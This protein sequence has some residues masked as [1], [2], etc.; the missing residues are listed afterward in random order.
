[1]CDRAVHDGQVT[2]VRRAVDAGVLEILRCPVCRGRIRER[3]D[4]LLCEA[5][6][7]SFELDGDI[8]LF[9]HDDLPGAVAK[10]REMAGW[11][12]KARTEGW[13]EP[14]DEIDRR[15]PWVEPELAG[16]LW[17][18]NAHSFSIMLDR[19]TQSG[20]RVLE[21]GAAKCW[22]APHLFAR[23]CS[24]VASDTLTDAKIGLGRGSFYGEFPR[25]QADAEHLP[26]A[27]EV[28][29]TTF[30]VATLHHALDLTAMVREMARV[31]RR[32]GFVFAL[33]EGSRGLFAS[34][35]SP[36]QAAEKELGI[37]EHVH[38]V[39]TYFAS[40]VRA[41][42]RVRRMER[43]EGWPLVGIGRVLEGLP[44][45][46]MTLGTLVHLSTGTYAGVSIYSRK[47]A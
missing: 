35:D 18:A 46:G 5:C 8:P 3:E 41:G 23:G 26:F 6:G 47:P 11:V 42:L 36:E 38:T 25:V 27:D 37:N 20:M 28:F 16:E 7:R 31:T 43:A 10:K 45:V 9:L 32:G 2:I 17:L 30:C 33:N 15:L 4:A 44:K 34:G 40:F 24:Y 13:Y 1:V 14:D 22:A 19:Y 12:A 21:I 29:D 39:W